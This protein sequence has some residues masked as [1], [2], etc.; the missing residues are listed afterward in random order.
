VCGLNPATNFAE[1]RK[2]AL[3]KNEVSYIDPMEN[4][5]FSIEIGITEG[6]ALIKTLY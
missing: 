3:E 6:D 5:Q 4:R 2:Q 1:G